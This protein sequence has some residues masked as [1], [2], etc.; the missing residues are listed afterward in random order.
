MI[1]KATQK[2]TRQTA[3]KVRLV[4][5]SVKNLSL[6]DAVRQL[7]VIE[8]RST[9]VVLKV[10]RQ[11]IANAV[12]NHGFS[13]E[14]LSLKSITVAPG[15]QFKRFRA[16]SRGRAHTI[17]KRSCHVTVELNAAEAK[18][19][20]VAAPKTESKTKK[21]VKTEKKVATKK[22]TT[23]KTKTAEK[24]VKKVTKTKVQKEK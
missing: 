24:V 18:K 11:A 9:I 23:V 4:A 21:V 2:N 13:I 14:D 6:T 22:K 7:A 5:N 10:L 15:P 16:V 19:E 3:R 8:R 1:I 17:V 20:V 12:H